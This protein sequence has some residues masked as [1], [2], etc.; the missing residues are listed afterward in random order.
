MMKSRNLCLKLCLVVFP[1]VLL[2]AFTSGAEGKWAL[3]GEMGQQTGIKG[4]VLDATGQPLPGAT[5]RI[6]DGEGI[7]STDANGRFNLAA[8]DGQI[9]LISFT[10]YLSKEVAVIGNADLSITLL[11]DA[12]ALDEVVVVGYSTQRRSSVTGAVASVNMTDLETR[13]VPNVA[14]SLQGQVAG[15]QITQSSGAPGDGINVRIRGEGTIGNNN[16]LYVIDGVPSRDITFLNPSDIESMSVLKDASAAAI[17]GSRASAGV[18]VITTK[19][20]KVGQKA[21]NINYFGGLQQVANLPKLLNTPQYLNVLEKAWNN[22]GITG[23][24]PYTLDKSRTDLANT[25]WLD[26][27][28]ETGKTNSVELSASGGNE[29]TQ[30]LISGGYYRQNGIVIFDNDQYERINFRVN[31]NSALSDRFKIGT[32]M[33]MAY[34]KRDQISAKGDAP[35]IIRH[36]L[37]RPPLLSV[38]KDPSDPTWSAADPFTDLPFYRN[39]QANTGYESNKY[40]YTRNPVAAAYFTDNVFSQ[41]KTFGNVFGEYALLADKSLKFRTNV[42]IDLNVN[43]TKAFFENYGDDDG[44]ASPNDL[45]KGRIN[46]PD[47][48]NEDRGTD[49]TLTWNNVLSYD[50]MFGSHH[51]SALAGTEYIKN[52]ASSINGSRRRYDYTL[53]TFRYLDYGSTLLDLWNG[54]SGSEYSLFSIF[55]SATYEYEGKYMITANL[56]ADESS[57]FGENHRWGYFPSVSVGW[58]M[59]KEQ[60][61]QAISWISDL[62]LRAST[63]TL[64]NQEIDNY[65]Y[66]TLMKRVGENYLIDRYGNPDLKW[67]TT[68]QHNIGLDASF[69]DDHV[70]LTAD[71][72]IKDTRDI[73]LPISLPSLVGNVQPTIVNA[74]QVKNKGFEFSLGY[75][76][77]TENGFRYGLNANLATL[78]NEVVK[79]HPNVPYISGTATRT[80]VGNPLNAY[81][82]YLVEGIYQNQQEVNTHLSGVENPTQ[83]PGDIRFK[84]LNGDGM[85]N[86]QDRDFMGNPIPKLTYGLNLSAAYK[87]FDLAVLIQGVQGV[88][89]Y[90]DGRKILDFDTRPFNY[91]TDVLGAWDGEGTS[92]T[93]PRLTFN[94][95]GSSRVS[96]IVLEDASYARLKNVELGYSFGSLIKNTKAF[97]NMRV[98]VS[99]QNLITLTDY[100]GLDPE[101]TDLIDMGTYPASR[102]FLFGINVTF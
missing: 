5:V 45:G 75:R 70:S 19:Q 14:Q 66:L 76:N 95:N 98:Y 89:R 55:G 20:G 34:S 23:E 13:R 4:S 90:N 1:S 74:G 36:A 93:I 65:A 71:Y 84:D 57:R 22:S 69:F 44:S 77:T 86:D 32:N 17:Y 38:Y 58:A 82:G 64:G 96:T 51:I 59:G 61:M 31:V 52:N 60:F 47:G 43:H 42:G 35:G 15:V 80:Q 26:E 101:S 30:Y 72:F 9:L 8:K 2:P 81:F 83:K 91:T 28:F 50:K 100:K 88:D 68:V 87:G 85:I 48:L 54:G 37:L 39:N 25:D 63:G 56:R 18:V 21:F 97:K 40:E 78:S 62:R 11:E 73:L 79:L 16:P 102:T 24:N 53:P 12:A 6:K 49:F 3:I 99:G 29:K 33:Q 10:G 92:N 46:R 7:T 41:I 94:D 27:L 67:E